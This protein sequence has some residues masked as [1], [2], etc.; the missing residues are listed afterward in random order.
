MLLFLYY[1]IH[2][3]CIP[4]KEFYYQ[5]TVPDYTLGHLKIYIVL[6]MA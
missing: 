5:H 6:R 2:L 3:L 1:S 4:S